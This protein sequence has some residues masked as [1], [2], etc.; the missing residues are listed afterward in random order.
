M[1]GRVLNAFSVDVEDWY[2][3][4]DFEDRIPLEN[5]SDYESR[6]VQNTRRLL[7]MLRE[8]DVRGTFFILTWNA[9]RHPDLVA[10]IAAEGEDDDGQDTGDESA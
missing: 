9:V 6:V 8:V 2:Q 10:E 4:S 3:V 5:W 1:S 7:D